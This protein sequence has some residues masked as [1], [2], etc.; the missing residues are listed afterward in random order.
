MSET[1]PRQQIELWIKDV[2]KRRGWKITQWAKMADV[3]PQTIYRFRSGQHKTI[4]RRNMEKL[5]EASTRPV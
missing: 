1:T 2:C 4:S 5:Y 3:P